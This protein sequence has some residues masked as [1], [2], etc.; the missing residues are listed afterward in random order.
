[1]IPELKDLRRK[2]RKQKL[3]IREGTYFQDADELVTLERKFVCET[4]LDS[5]LLYID[6]F[7][8]PLYVLI[9]VCM[10]D[11]SVSYVFGLMKSYDVWFDWLRLE[12]LKRETGEWKRI[13]RSVNGPW[14]ST[15]ADDYHIFVYADGMERINLALKKN[16]PNGAAVN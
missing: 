9:R 2:C 5:A 12:E 10:L 13:V 14:I 4:F 16:K 3:K 6:M 15:N 7:I 11:F 8:Y 1:M